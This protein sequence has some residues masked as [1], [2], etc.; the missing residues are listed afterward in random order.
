MRENLAPQ[1][2][3]VPMLAKLVPALPRDDERWGFEFN[4]DGIRAVAQID[5]G[6]LSPA[7]RNRLDMTGRYPELRAL[8]AALGPHS[9]LLDGEIVGFDASGRRTFEALRQRMGLEGGERVQADPGIGIAYMI[10]DVLVL[11]GRSL[12][13]EPY[14]ERRSVLEA[15][16]SRERTG[17]RRRTRRA[18]AIS[19][20]RRVASTGW[21]G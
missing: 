20:S 2:L 19:S 4:W 13:A 18:A 10:F 1:W 16:N 3:L 6:T 9:A 15:S 5:R 12:L 8:A 21:R 17:T 11:D 14:T 7:S